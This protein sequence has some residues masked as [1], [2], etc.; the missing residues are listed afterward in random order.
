MLWIIIEYRQIKLIKSGGE[1]VQSTLLWNEKKQVA[2][3]MRSKEEANDYRYFPEPDL[4]NLL[5]KDDWIGEVKA[6]LPELPDKKSARLERDYSIREYDALVLTD[7]RALADYYEDVMKTYEDGQLASNWI[8]TE[9]LGLLKEAKLEISESKV[10]PETMAELLT[11]VK[12]G[13]LSGKMAKEVFAEMFASG[14][15]PEDIIK[16]KY[17]GIR[18][19]LQNDLLQAQANNPEMEEAEEDIEVSYQGTELEIGFNVSY[20][21]D[22]LGA[23]TEETVVLE[24]GDANSSCVVHPQQDQ[25]CTYVI[26][27]MRL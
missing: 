5:V 1:V 12:E 22:A 18:L 11:K 21:L 19:R 4:V 9:F 17:R 14:K 15:A 8:Q 20:L 13:E 27:P 3:L 25:S 7:S 24:L 6:N 16:E 10:S 23:V 2:E 26:M